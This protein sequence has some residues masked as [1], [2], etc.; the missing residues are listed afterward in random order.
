VKKLTSE[1]L[2]ILRCPECGKKLRLLSG[3]FEVGILVCSNN[4]LHRYE[5]KESVPIL[6]SKTKTKG[7]LGSLGFRE[8]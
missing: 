7:R 6:M 3:S 4:E 1:L 5:I 8:K 2:D